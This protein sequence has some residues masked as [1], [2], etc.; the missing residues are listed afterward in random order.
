M[1]HFEES[2][3]RGERAGRWW[4]GW[5][6]EGRREAGCFFGEEC[7]AAAEPTSTGCGLVLHQPVPQ[8]CTATIKHCETVPG[9]NS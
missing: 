3:K 7:V 1:K 4:R 9:S 5:R 8:P 6:D 2:S